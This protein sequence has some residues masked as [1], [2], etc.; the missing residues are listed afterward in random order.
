M[1]VDRRW[2]LSAILAALAPATGSWAAGAAW[3]GEAPLG[4]AQPFS[5]EELK[6]RAR[7][8]AAQPHR[9]AP[10]P[11][12][13]LLRAIDYDAFGRVT[14]KP[15]A[16]LWRGA[17]G[18]RLFPLA[19]GSSAPV[20]IHVVSGGQ[21]RPVLHAA[22]LFDMPA[23]SP[24]RRLG[25][26]AG[27]GGFRLMN[28][29]DRTDW[30]AWL[31]ASYWRSADPFNQYGLSA[32]GLAIDTATA[33]PEEFP[34]FTSFWIEHPPAGGPIVYALLDGP[35][36]AGAY[37]IGHERGPG[38]LK[39]RIT[40][41][42]NF[43]KAVARLG[44]APLTS[45]YWYG[46]SERTPADD[47][48]PQIHDSDGLAIWTGAGERIWR[49]LHNPPRVTTSTFLDRRPRGYG[50]MQRDRNFA[51][52]QDDGVF[53]EKRPSAW[54]EPLG[55]WGAGSV[56]L[57]EIPTKRETE[58]NI[59][60]FWTPA[61]TVGRGTRL[62]VDYR[63]HW[64]DQ[65]PAAPGVARVTATRFGQGG[66]PGEP[67]QAGR[68]KF[69]VDFA[70]ATLAGLERGDAEPVVSASRGAAVAAAAYPVVGQTGWRL[71]FD[72]DIA[73]GVTDLRAYLRKGESA[74]TETWIY[75]VA[76]A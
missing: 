17:D 21:A 24:V 58:D 66:R 55:D 34:V 38:G 57:V 26:Q 73:P 35:S 62:D 49:P 44:L 3:P 68:R 50:L 37:R 27:F 47:W 40:A 7:S 11:A 4:P 9:P 63:L 45:M 2:T 48:R 28:A 69:V 71:M 1:D 74:L 75:Q 10:A 46:Q 31:R 54:V 36:V 59:V 76:A 5:F 25:D 39:Q 42:L 12:A 20:A 33:S 67:V 29:D 22:S 19:S 61:R 64:S 13:E 52:Y 53:Y 16:T 51:D 32:R 41:Q 23:D 6:A 72:I 65:E 18:V 15:Q 60:A 56:Q 8:L 14:Y 70:G 30:A 43:R